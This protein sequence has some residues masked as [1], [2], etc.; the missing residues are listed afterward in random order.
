VR[1]LEKQ[2]IL[3]MTEGLLQGILEPSPILG[4]T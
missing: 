4:L 2:P 3:A 1:P